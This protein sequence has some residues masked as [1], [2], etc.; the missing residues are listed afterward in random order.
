MVDVSVVVADCGQTSEDKGPKPLNYI[1]RDPAFHLDTPGY[2]LHA[3][4]LHLFICRQIPYFQQ[5]HSM[6]PI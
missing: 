5:Q 3:Q 6:S 4:P 2:L 1:T